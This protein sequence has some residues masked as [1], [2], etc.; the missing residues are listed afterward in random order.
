MTK[1][2]YEALEALCMM[3]EQY[4]G[5]DWGHEFM[6]AGEHCADVLDKYDLLKNDKGTGG[7]VDWDKFKEL[8]TQIK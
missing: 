2:L 5:G 8:E 1:E 4:C 3:W 6:S 7:E